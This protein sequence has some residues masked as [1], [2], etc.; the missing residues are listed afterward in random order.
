MVECSLY[1]NKTEAATDEKYSWHVPSSCPRFYLSST[2]FNL[3]RFHF[4]TCFPFIDIRASRERLG[5]K[6]V[7]PRHIVGPSFIELHFAHTSEVSSSNNGAPI[8]A[9]AS[10]KCTRQFSVRATFLLEH[11]IDSHIEPS[12]SPA[13]KRR[14]CLCTMLILALSFLITSWST[15]S[16]G[17]SS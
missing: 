16:I 9:Q 15:E 3:F 8:S 2:V 4:L 1:R 12:P 14:S 10:D 7:R 6:S 11:A 5:H 13:V 17:L